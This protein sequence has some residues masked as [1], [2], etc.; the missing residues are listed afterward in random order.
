MAPA[1]KWTRVLLFFSLIVMT[2]AMAASPVRAALSPIVAKSIARWSGNMTPTG[3]PIDPRSEEPLA[4]AS[5]RP[6]TLRT[7]A[8]QFTVATSASPS[9]SVGVN[10]RFDYAN[11]TASVNADAREDALTPEQ[12]ATLANRS[13]SR[14]DLGPWQPGNSGSASRGGSASLARGGNRSAGASASASS[15]ASAGNAG[16]SGSAGSGSGGGSGS[17]G[18][19]GGGPT[20]VPT[21][22]PGETSGVF[23]EYTNGLP[24]L[25]GSGTTGSGAVTGLTTTAVAANPEPSTLLLLGTGIVAVAGALRRRM[26]RQV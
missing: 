17:S 8:D 9:S 23:T 7:G 3:V 16:N 15:S 18:S 20:R 24:E 5:S 14:F 26:A 4:Q 21:P 11:S 2:T 13:A 22:P 12:L 1:L 19:S 6:A 25:T 10:D